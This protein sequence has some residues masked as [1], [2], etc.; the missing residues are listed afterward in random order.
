VLPDQGQ[1]GGAAYSPSGA[2]LA[3]AIARGNPEDEMG[4]VVLR[5]EQGDDPVPIAT[6]APGYFERLLWV[7]EEQMVVGA[8]ASES[9]SV[10]RLSVDGTRTDVGEGRLIGLMRPPQASAARLDDLVRRGDVEL[11][12]VTANGEI[13]GPG[14]EV[15]VYNPGADDV[16]A[17]IPCGFIFEPDDGSNQRLMAVQEVAASIPAGGQAILVAYV[18][19][20]DSHSD[21]PAQG[22]GYALGSM[23][24]GTLMELAQ[25]ACREDLG[26]SLNPLDGMGVMGAGWIISEGMT[27]S[28]MAPD[29][30]GGTLGETLSQFMGL[31][32]QPALGWLDRCGIPVP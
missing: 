12:R 32:E 4:Q 27:F 18:V 22:A 16:I 15:E 3:Y 19:C 29:D 21:T 13:A 6:Q 11:Q 14:I 30:V 8:F 5:L 28:E 26:A 9:E 31:L 23:Q 25:C 10:D 17:T 7:D 2:R 24:T 20:I 1:Q